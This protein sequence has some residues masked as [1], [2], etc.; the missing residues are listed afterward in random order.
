MNEKH[1]RS[2]SVTVSAVL[3]AVEFLGCD[4][5]VVHRCTD[6][7]ARCRPGDVFVARTTRRGDGHEAVMQAV[8]RGAGGVIAERIIP[9]EGVPLCLVPDADVALARLTHALAGNPAAA[10]RLI[11]VAGTSG[12]TTT[13]WLTASVLAEAGARVGVLSDLGCVDALGAT[14]EPADYGTARGCARWL[15]RLVTSG[16]THAV[17][18]VSSPML[19]R[20]TL[21]GVSCDTVVVTNLAAAHAGPHGTPRACRTVVARI[22]DSLAADGCLITGSDRGPLGWLR[23][24]AAASKPRAT[25]VLAG[26]GG[27]ADVT[28]T[29][30]ERSIFGRTVLV[31]AGAGMVPVE[32]DTPVVP[33]VRDAVLAAA[34]GMRFGIPLERIARGIEAAGAVP[35]RVERIDRGQDA[36][37]FVDS[38]SST[39]ALA[40]TLASLRRLTPGRLVA[41]AD[42]GW[43][44]GLTNAA[45]V[46]R[47]CDEVLVVP[48]GLLDAEATGPDL[49]AYARLDRLL[50][51]LGRG[52]CLVVLGR[53]TRA[54][55]GP[56]PAAPFPLADVVDGW[57]QLAHPPLSAGRAA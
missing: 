22:L 46:M 36:A 52:D 10:L 45:P 24:R 7:P 12:K 23:R 1:A 35:G 11:A 20:H 6:E 2:G 44:R 19:A 42:R 9:T 15:A 54:G 4:D 21:A 57:L 37:V 47:R 51:A 18:E 34:V 50:S 56:V 8:R 38:P 5:L 40:A 26:L 14:A 43:L 32:V 16:C 27:G 31:R 29:A 41:V 17:V 28:A 3:D 49:A 30:V 13:A 25:Q 55:R 39:H 33:F 48:R 53:P